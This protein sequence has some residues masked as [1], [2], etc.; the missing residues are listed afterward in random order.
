MYHPRYSTYIASSTRKWIVFL[1]DGTLG[2][3]LI[4]KS[5]T[6]N[7]RV[8]A[9]SFFI[10]S[11]L[12]CH[13]DSAIVQS[14]SKTCRNRCFIDLSAVRQD[15]VFTMCCLNCSKLFLE[16]VIAKTRSGVS[17]SSRQWWTVIQETQLQWVSG[18]AECREQGTGK[19]ETY[20]CA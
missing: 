1:W 15:D 17:N 13:R 3:S 10:I 2:E 4:N 5:D 11:L 14:A 8:C 18:K 9:F 7:W 19:A 6:W 20:S 12:S 16:S